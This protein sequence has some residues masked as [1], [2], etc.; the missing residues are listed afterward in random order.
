MAPFP[1]CTLSVI[2]AVPLW[3]ATGVTVTLRFAPLPLIVMLPFATTAAFD[4][5]A[6]TASNA[7]VVSASPTVNASGPTAAPLLT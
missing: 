7:G 2:V 6:V 1:S 3:P 4:D 5:V